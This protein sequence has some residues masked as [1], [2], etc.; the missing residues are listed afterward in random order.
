MT[1]G[2]RVELWGDRALFTRPELKVERMSYDVPTPSAMRGALEAIY[3]HPGMAMKIDRIHVLNRISFASVRRNEMKS[4][5]NASSMKSAM[6]GKSAL[7]HLGS[8]SSKDEIQQRASLVLIDVR[9]VVDA[10]FEMTDKAEEGD[11][12][13]K[14]QSIFNR[15]L[16]KGQC[17]SQPYFGCR[18][19]SAYFKPYEGEGEPTGYYSE[20]GERDLGLMLY[21]MDFSN[22]QNITPMFFHAVMRDGVIDVAGSEVLR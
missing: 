6:L 5:G 19:F 14:F 15:R 10:H 22:S 11:N 8:S 12:P 17:Y 18:E 4:K 1:Y 13:G 2:F 9:Y 3:W 21:D 7:P 16:A 20:S